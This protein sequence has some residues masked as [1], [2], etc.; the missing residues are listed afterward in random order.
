[1]SY[2][3]NYNILDFGFYVK[4]QGFLYELFDLW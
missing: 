1:M 3:V 4:Y 2:F